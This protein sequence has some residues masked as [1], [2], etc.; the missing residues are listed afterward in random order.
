MDSIT[1]LFVDY[2]NENMKNKVTEKKAQKDKGSMTIEISDTMITA[3]LVASCLF[4]TAVFFGICC[5]IKQAKELNK[6]VKLASMRGQGL[7][8]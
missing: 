2:K 7:E 6:K 3:V 5:C 1:Q 8:F 4:A